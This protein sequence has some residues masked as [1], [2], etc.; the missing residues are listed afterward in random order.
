M[1]KA[2]KPAAEKKSKVASATKKAA[3]LK[4]AGVAIEKAS[5]DALAKLQQLNRGH[6]LQAD[7]A[8]CLGSYRAD[9]NPVGLFETVGHAVALLK[10]ELKNK[11]KGITASFIAGLEKALQT[12]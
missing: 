5:E 7:I 8:W 12:R 11:T 2:S 3:K 1:A 4:P 6:Q 9:Q 10:T